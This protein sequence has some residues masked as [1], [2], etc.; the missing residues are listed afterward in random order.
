MSVNG[1]AD[2]HGRKQREY[3]RL[4]RNH[5]HGFEHRD[6]GLT[7]TGLEFRLQGLGDLVGA[8]TEREF[9]LAGSVVR[10]AA[11]EVSEVIR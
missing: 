3:K 5:D 9:V 8:A 11:R 10:V 1:H 6:A 7:K 4:Y 2:E